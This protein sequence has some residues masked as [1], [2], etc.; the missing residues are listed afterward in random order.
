MADREQLRIFVSHSAEDKPFCDALAAALRGAGADVWY[1]EQSLGAGHLLNV[2]SHELSSRPVFIV[3]LSKAAFASRWVTQEC[4]WAFNLYNREPDRVILPVVVQPITPSDFN[5]W[6]WLESF[7]R[8]EGRD[9][10]PLPASEAI[11]KTLQLLALIS[12]SN[13]ATA[14]RS[15]ATV[16]RG[17]RNVLWVDDIPSNNFYER[18]TL[19]GAGIAV[20]L[21]TSTDD[22]LG[23]LVRHHFDAIISDMG[24]PPDNLAGYTL[25]E[26]VRKLGKNVPFVLY[27]SSRDP[28]QVADAK[29][30]GAFGQTNAPDELFT[31]I[32]AA[33]G[34]E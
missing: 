10:V 1:D 18:R 7:R 5:A 25:L 28:K 30:R 21:S 8:V 16:R 27:T 20:T 15:A 23:K 3:I 9:G 31:L 13:E 32:R 4:Q 12:P 19:E 26:E 11:A 22:A 2:I 34:L 6:L 14:L 24:R 29:Q 17:G 33:L